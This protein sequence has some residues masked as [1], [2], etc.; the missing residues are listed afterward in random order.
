QSL[1]DSPVAGRQAIIDAMDDFVIQHFESAAR[2]AMPKAPQPGAA[3]RRLFKLKALL[4]QYKA[5]HRRFHRVKSKLA[6]RPS[7]RNAASWRSA[8][9]QLQSQLLSARASW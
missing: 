2:D 3:T 8:L 9:P 6:A 4:R 5:A 7:H 1:N